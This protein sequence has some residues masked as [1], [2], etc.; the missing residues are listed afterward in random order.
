MDSLATLYNNKNLHTKDF[1]ISVNGKTLVTDKDKSVST[2]APVFKGASDSDVMTYFKF[3]SGVDTMPTVKIISG[4]GT[5][6][7]VKVTEGPNAGSSV[8]L[9]DFST[10]ASQT[11]ARWTIDIQRPDINKGR[12]VEMKFQ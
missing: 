9:R 4:K 11:K 10:S 12:S 1:T 2:G 7:S 6:Y 3:L 5:V 8:T